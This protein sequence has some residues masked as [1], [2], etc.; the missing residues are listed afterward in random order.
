MEPKTKFIIVLVLLA[1]GGYF[2]WTWFAGKAESATDDELFAQYRIGNPLWPANVEAHKRVESGKISVT[3]LRNKAGAKDERTRA[4][5]FRLMSL[6]SGG[7]RTDLFKYIDSV[8][9]SNP[10]AEIRTQM[11]HTCLEFG[12][13]G[14]HE[15]IAFLCVKAVND[16]DPVIEAD[17]AS[18]LR[19]LTG[20]S[21][22]KRE[23][24]RQWWNSQAGRFKIPADRIRKK[25][26]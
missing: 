15:V 11:I 12:R 5:A 21:F 8:W 22:H 23:E 13:D 9:G 6:V 19:E 16:Q 2:A 20:F 3:E 26:A 18:A 4:V 7:S 17:A 14:M 1:V 24:W 10:A 25:A